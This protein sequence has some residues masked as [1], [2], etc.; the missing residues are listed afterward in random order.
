VLII[1]A[2][3]F[4]IQLVSPWWGILPVCLIIGLL[5]SNV[6]HS[7][8]LAGFLALFLI[9]AGFSWWIDVQNHSILS[10]RVI[11]LFPVPHHSSVLI[12]ITGILGG[13]I[14]GMATLTG[15]TFRRLIQK[16]DIAKRYY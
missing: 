2:A 13:L 10:E 1:A 16:E 8:F 6:N 11:R 7:P 5:T 4:G 12:L 15:H 14:G 3:C 9:W